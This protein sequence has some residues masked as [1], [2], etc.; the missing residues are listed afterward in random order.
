MAQ[1]NTHETADSRPD[2]PKTHGTNGDSDEGM[3][4]RDI[5]D[6]YADYATWIS[7]LRWLDHLFTGTYRRRQFAQADGR[8]LDVACGAGSN[9]RY[10]SEA[11]EIVGIDVSEP[12]LEQARAELDALERGGT[13]AQMD[14]QDL[15]FDDD[16][17][18]TVISSFSTCTFP[19]QVAA[20][21]EMQRVCRPDGRILLLEHGRSD[22]ALVA[23]YQEW[24]A[25]SHYE[26]S[27]CR[28][29]QEPLEVVRRAGLSVD[30][31]ETA[32]FGRLTRIVC[33]G[34]ATDRREVNR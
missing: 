1:H 17:F 6:A 32:Q 24:R 15:E 21:R 3:T 16:S 14:A 13:V 20:L 18:D 25:D 34:G 11:T 31:V 28:L 9:F 8:V 29:T 10:L 4:V 12:L 7:R 33:N 22:S 26:R 2:G 23:R 27:G 30:D 5:Q 19:D